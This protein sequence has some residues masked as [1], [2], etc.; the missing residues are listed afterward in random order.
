MEFDLRL[1][2]LT[3]LSKSNTEAAEAA[4]RKEFDKVAA[5]LVTD[6]QYDYLE[7]HLEVLNAIG[8]RFSSAAVEI[9]LTFIRTIESRGVTY[10]PR[11]TIFDNEI[12]KYHNASS[13]IVHALDALISLRYLEMKPVLH[14]LLTLSQ[15]SSEAVRNKAAEGLKA[16]A[17][18][19]IDVLYGDNTR[20]GIGA[21]PQKQIVDELESLTPDVL[22]KYF[23][24]VLV[25]IDE[26]LSPTI[27]GTSWTY[28]T[29]TWSQGATP[30]LPTVADVRLRSIEL[31]K[32]MYGLANT[33]SE[34]LAVISSLN[35]ATR[36]HHIG[37]SDEATIKMIVRDTLAVLEFFTV[38]IPTDNLS[39]I[40]KIE[41]NSYWIFFHAITGEIETSALGVQAAISMHTEYQIY[42][43][44]IGFE[45]V[46]G[47]W[48]ELK[49]SD[50]G[51]EDSDNFRKEKASDYAASITLD[52]YAE[53]RQRIL[54]YAETQSEDLA[55]FPIFYYFLESFATKQP[56]LALQLIS[57]DAGR[58][59][60]FLIPLL[61]GLS[62]GSQADGTKSLV[63]TW[64]KQGLYLNQST[65]QFL[66][67]EHLDHDLL[68]LLLRRATELEDLNTI[69]AVMSVAV[70]NYTSDKEFLINDFFL[71]ALEVLTERSKPYWIFDFWF[72]R[73][74]RAVIKNLSNSGIDLILRNLLALE[75]ID[76][77][78]EE[79]LYLI[80]QRAPKKVLQYLC[81]RLSMEAK[82]REKGV[83]SFDA[84]PYQLHKLNEPL[85][86]VPGEAVRAVREQY[87]G[88]YSMFIYR[89]AHLLKS[90]FPQFPAEFEA[91]LLN[92][93]RSGG[94][95]NFEFVLAVLRNYEG[96]PFIH[97]ICKEIVKSVPSDSQF[98]TEVAIAL[99]STGV[100]SG[101]F[102]FAEAFE[103]KK[104]EIR[105][106]VND[107]EEK[108]QDFAKWYIA[109]LEQ[110]SAADRKRAE[111][112]IALR[113][114]RYG[115]QE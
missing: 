103:R 96:E 52:N 51:W 12:S 98:R 32:R 34:K 23:S 38:L 19:N 62:A 111:E 2:A 91:E 95:A 74:L 73:E 39:I 45:G 50:S 25:L 61:R 84:I 115:E 21:A 80:A 89:G 31:L 33:V 41:S 77:H 35:A 6:T 85:S 40:Q 106:W 44:L 9:L 55:T 5:A 22:K 37:K 66:S 87:E 58:V 75:E 99:E 65:R 76:Y 68:A 16:S 113:K 71:P 56:A 53:W 81:Q 18:Y 59:D 13:L 47:E 110:M 28:K 93:V 7:Q 72:R 11:D 83:S 112:D 60:R 43:I 24:A 92:I 82:M 8:H 1:K 70:S 36:T 4:L 10:S 107:P 17:G 57:N 94:N 102:G 14:A 109:G 54:K 86:R 30:A 90:I 49:K 79:V 88:D 104:N 42:K 27:Q 15:H 20:P 108:I 114:Y 100:V 48:A 26:L 29:V 63:V 69:T 101:E 67:N 46:F 97:Q 78:A 105:D 3:R 64:I